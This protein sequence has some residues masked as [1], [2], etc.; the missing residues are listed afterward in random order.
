MKPFIH[1]A[2]CLLFTAIL[3]LSACVFAGPGHDD[4]GGA[5]VNARGDHDQGR[6]DDAG[7][8]C[9]SDHRGDGCQDP[10]HP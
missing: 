8:G 2:T 7:K 9:D 10:G 4:R 5:Q 1:L 3:G 6:Q